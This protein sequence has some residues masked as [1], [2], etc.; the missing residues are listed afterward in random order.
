MAGITGVTTKKDAKGNL[1]EIR[2]NTKK[3]PD[4]IGK[5]KSIGLIEK[6]PFEK[7]FEQAADV[8]EVFDR[9]IKHIEDTWEAK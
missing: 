4:A 5:L 3:N 7:K 1:A 8:D 6:T 9:L 2:I